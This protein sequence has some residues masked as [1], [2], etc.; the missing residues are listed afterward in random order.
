MLAFLVDLENKPGG[1]ARVAEAIA[2]KGV[3]IESISGAACGDAGRAAILTNDAGTTRKALG[4]IGCTF[5]E[6]EAT[7]VTLRHEAGSLAKV[8]RRLGDAGVNI[9]ALL[10]VGMDGGDVRVAIVTNDPVKAGELLSRA[11]IRR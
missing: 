6:M 8:A 5:S 9:E 1:L 7:E 2:A 4:E 3:N 10:P 11:G